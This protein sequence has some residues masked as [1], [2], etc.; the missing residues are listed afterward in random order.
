MVAFAPSKILMG[1]A[2]MLKQ[3][4]NFVGVSGVILT[5]FML[6]LTGLAAVLGGF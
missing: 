5:V 2:Q 6:A 1:R 4:I 3:F